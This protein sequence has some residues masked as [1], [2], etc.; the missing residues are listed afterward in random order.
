MGFGGSAMGVQGLRL[1]N[2]GFRGFGGSG[3]R[4]FADLGVLVI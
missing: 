2:L 4:G 1:R 3:F